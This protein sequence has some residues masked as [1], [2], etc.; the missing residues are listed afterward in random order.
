[1]S[2]YIAVSLQRLWYTLARHIKRNTGKDDG[3]LWQSMIRG[4]PAKMMVYFGKV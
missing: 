1:M 2:V 4:T 3:I